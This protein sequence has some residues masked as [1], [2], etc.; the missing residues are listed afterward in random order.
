MLSSINCAL[1][2]KTILRVWNGYSKWM[3]KLDN[4]RRRGTFKLKKRHRLVD[5]WQVD[6]K[7]VAF[8]S[9]R[10]GI[11]RLLIKS[12]VIE[13]TTCSAL[14]VK[15]G[16]MIFTK[17]QIKR[18]IGIVRIFE[19]IFDF[20]ELESGHLNSRNNRSVFQLDI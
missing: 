7:N 4:P 2:V 5:S 14:M 16:R 15:G 1:Y 8:T 12:F 10:H 17:K 20:Y 13:Q 11:N 9:R 6:P 19:S 3:K 18:K